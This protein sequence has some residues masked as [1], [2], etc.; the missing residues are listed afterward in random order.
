MT[1]I[2]L[3]RIESEN[4]CQDLLIRNTTIL[5]KKKKDATAFYNHQI[6]QLKIMFGD[7]AHVES[8]VSMESLEVQDEPYFEEYDVIT[9]LREAQ[10]NG[11][12]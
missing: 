5:F 10:R 3:V 2:Y 11:N 9:K 1:T 6:E 12:G 7:D 8:H 4:G